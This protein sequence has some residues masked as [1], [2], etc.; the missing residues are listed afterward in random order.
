MKEFFA[1]GIKNSFKFI[2]DHD[3]ICLFSLVFL[4][5]N[6]N[7]RL[8]GSGDTIPASLLPFSILEN[9][10]LYLDQFVHYYENKFEN[11]YFFRE[12][13]GHYL[14]AYPIVA[15]ILITPL[16]II[17]FLFFKLNH[18]PMDLFHPGFALVV[19]IM[20]KLSASLIASISVIFVYLSVKEL[21]NKGIAAIVAIIFAFATNTWTISSQGLWQHGLGELLLSMLIYLVLV[22]EKKKSDKIIICLGAISGLFVF[23]RPVDSM[24]ILPVIYYVLDLRGKK[25]IYYTCAMFLSSAP[26]IF[27]NFYY[28]GSLFGGYGALIGIFDLGSEMAGRLT[29]LL[30]SPSRGLFIYTP[31]LLF[32]FPGYFSNFYIENKKIKK[33]LL[34]FGFSIFAQILVYSAFKIWWAGWS[35]G[36]R[37]L[38]DILPIMAVFLGLFLK[39]LNCNAKNTK[40]LFVIVLFIILLIWS[41]FTQFVG[42]FYYPNGNWDGELNVDLHPEKLW[43][44]SDTQIERTYRAGILP[45][46]NYVGILKLFLKQEKANDLLLNALLSN[47]WHGIEVWDGVPTRWM[48][49][50][51]YLIVCSS[52][53]YTSE[54]VLQ[55]LSF[56]RERTLEIYLNDEL[57]AHVAVPTSFINVR[58]PINLFKGTNTVRLHVPEG[59]ERPC[60]KQELNNPDSR[61][62]SIAMQ[63]SSISQARGQQAG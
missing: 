59:C 9:H 52:A 35:Y 38:T 16:Y 4:V 37:F 62:L 36:P 34:I 7:G 31:V 2:R 41:V 40:K 63:N 20:E 60:D 50:D 47:G 21:T 22:N 30:V 17:L 6:I 18:Y 45:P 5:Y 61:C 3:A 56:Y 39:E 24:L 25:I 57:L 8:I 51:A 53:N 46:T 23:N 15:P 11:T 58:V 32:A 1:T 12:I 43:D 28:F 33:F 49:G 54:L 19:P 55:A 44:W 14:S 29:G 42:A 26:F 27:Y 10:N 48:Q 13:N